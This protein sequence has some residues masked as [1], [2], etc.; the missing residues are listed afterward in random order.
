MYCA[1]VLFFA[2]LYTVYSAV[3]RCTVLLFCSV[4]C[5]A[6]QFCAVMYCAAV[7][8][9]AML[10][11]VYSAVLRCTGAAVLFFPMLYSAVLCIA[12]L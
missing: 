8:F 3:L 11:T 6:V 1:A 4:L 5:H 9:F 7:L 2:M 12:V 10:Y